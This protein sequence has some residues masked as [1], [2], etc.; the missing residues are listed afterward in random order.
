MFQSDSEVPRL[1]V[2]SRRSRRIRRRKRELWCKVGVGIRDRDT[3]G[4]RRNE[5]QAVDRRQR[6]WLRTMTADKENEGRVNGGPKD[7]DEEDEEDEGRKRRRRGGKGAEGCGCN[8]GTG[9]LGRVMQVDSEIQVEEVLY[10]ADDHAQVS[11]RMRGWES[12]T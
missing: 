4:I 5:K 9:Q 11:R 7:E 1:F 2:R 10:Q 12:N 3:G 8:N 6:R